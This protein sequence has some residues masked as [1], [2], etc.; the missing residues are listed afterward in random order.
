MLY[1]NCTIYSNSFRFT[2]NHFL[3]GMTVSN[4]QLLTGLNDSGK[5]IANLERNIKYIIAN[6]K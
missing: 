2:R 6:A 4:I 1:S 3:S 5:K